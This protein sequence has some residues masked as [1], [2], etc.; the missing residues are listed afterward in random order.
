MCVCTAQSVALPVRKANL[1][2][3][4]APMQT[5]TIKE[6]SAG[7]ATQALTHI[8]TIFPANNS[9]PCC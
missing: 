9:V 3:T 6:V 4:Q 8:H 1:M 7:G 2:G 5:D